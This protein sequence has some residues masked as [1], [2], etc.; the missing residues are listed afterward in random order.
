MMKQFINATIYTVDANFSVADCMVIE[1]NKIIFIG[2]QH[3]FQSTDEIE[4]INCLGKCI[5]PGLIDPH[6]HFIDLGRTYFTAALHTTNSFDEVIEKVKSFQETNTREWLVGRGWNNNNWA[7]K[8]LPTKEVLDILFPNTPVFLVR[9]DS[10]VALINQT[11]IDRSKVLQQSFIDEGFIEMKD[12]KATGIVYDKAMFYMLPFV[13]ENDTVKKQIILK[14][15]EICIAFGLTSVGDAFMEHPDFKLFQS[16][17]EEDSLK[18]KLFGMFV[19]SKENK[20]FLSQNKGYKKGKFMISATKH[21][22]DGALGSRGAALLEPYTDD[23]LNKGLLLESDEYWNEEAQFCID[24]NLQMITHC[25][26]D[27]ANERIIQLY[28][29]Y[30]KGKNERRW[31]IEHVQILPNY[32]LQE[33]S[34]NQIIPSVQST[35]GTSDYTWAKDR[36]GDNR[37]KTAYRIKDLLE[38][39][40]MIVNGSD[41][42]IEKPNP[43]RGFYASI[44]RKDDNGQPAFGFDPSQ[45]ITRIEALKSM[46]IWAAYA[47]FQEKEIGSLEVHKHADFVISATD[48]L[49]CKEEDILHTSIDATYVDGELVFS[50]KPS[51]S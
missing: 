2:K 41:F 19:P 11:A 17:Y 1:D 35:H 15:Q 4:I 31:R 25:I 20:D 32:L 28:K 38:E 3:E 34:N 48:L 42:P 27:A 37:M 21:F 39:C 51:L 33:F 29:K 7:D 22:A 16:M 49:T 23:P 18:I 26:G 40:G 30:L 43:L 9:I 12:G 24:H 8:Q 14:A 44:T 46:T 47:Q 36:L 5:Y 10:H 45:K 50:R 13:Q 6:C